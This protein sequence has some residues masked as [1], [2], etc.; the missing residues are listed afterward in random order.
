MGARGVLFARVRI[1]LA[2]RRRVPLGDAA[3]GSKRLSLRGTFHEIAAPERLVFSAVLDGEAPDHEIRT[4]VTFDDHEGGTRV[5]LRQTYSK[6]SSAKTDGA[7]QGW[8]QS[9]DRLEAWLQAAVK[10]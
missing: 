9:L 8:T 2:P 10:K 6:V 3:A 4:T 5:T 1:R 7:Q